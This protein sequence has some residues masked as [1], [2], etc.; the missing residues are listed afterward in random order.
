MKSFIRPSGARE[1]R[2]ARLFF[3]LGSCQFKFVCHP[4]IFTVHILDKNALSFIVKITPCIHAK[5]LLRARDRMRNFPHPE[6]TPPS[7]P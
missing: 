7:A 3:V 1:G 2:G 5:K 6:R 4:L